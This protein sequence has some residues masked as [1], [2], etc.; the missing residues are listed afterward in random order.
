MRGEPV[1]LDH[2]FIGLK[3]I[4]EIGLDR[5][6][7]VVQ[8]AD[9]R[10]SILV[11]TQ[12]YRHELAKK[13]LQEFRPFYSFAENQSADGEADVFRVLGLNRKQEIDAY[14]LVGG[15]HYNRW[16]QQKVEIGGTIQAPQDMLR[17]SEAYKRWVAHYK[18]EPQADTL[19]KLEENPEK[20]DINRRIHRVSPVFILRGKEPEK[21][22]TSL[23]E[24]KILQGVGNASSTKLREAL[25]SK[26]RHNLIDLPYIGL[27]YIESHPE[28][29]DMLIHPEKYS[30]SAV[31]IEELSQMSWF[32][33][34]SGRLDPFTGG[35]LLK[36]LKRI[37]VLSLTDVLY[38]LIAQQARVGLVNMDAL[39]R[40]IAYKVGSYSVRYV[41]GRD[42][43]KVKNGIVSALPQN[44]IGLF[45]QYGIDGLHLAVKSVFGKA[46]EYLY[47]QPE[48]KC[49]LCPEF[50]PVMQRIYGWRNWEIGANPF[51]NSFGHFTVINKQHTPRI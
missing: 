40:I 38:A 23:E 35:L 15:D 4:A 41:P 32:V 44:H 27:E 7:Y 16:A 22:A 30:S 3:V 5:V 37:K 19:Q 47:G 39:R 36:A 14:Y 33:R 46:R 34:L 48:V 20:Y 42:E 1:P 50:R 12:P 49:H 25:Q 6:I 43:A 11:H 26:D 13:E 8:G 28:Y 29:K 10:K 24:V 21:I 9:K 51:A 17:G 45:N 31:T 18:V 2:L